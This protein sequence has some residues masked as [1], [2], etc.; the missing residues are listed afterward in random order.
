MEEG[1]RLRLFFQEFSLSE[2]FPPETKRCAEVS[3]EVIVALL[4]RRKGS[5]DPGWSGVIREIALKYDLTGEEIIAVCCYLIGFVDGGQ[6]G[7]RV[8]LNL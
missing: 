6:M 1:E 5:L 7:R 3:R 4:K 8:I 2:D